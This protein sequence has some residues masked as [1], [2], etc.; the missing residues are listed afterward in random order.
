M[1]LAMSAMS[2]SGIESDDTSFSWFCNP[3]ISSLYFKKQHFLYIH[4]IYKF[5]YMISTLKIINFLFLFC[6]VSLKQMVDE[7]EM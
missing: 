7:R 2:K 1:K 4:I 6:W 3:M 5:N